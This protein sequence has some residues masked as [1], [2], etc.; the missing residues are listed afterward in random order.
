MYEVKIESDLNKIKICICL[1][2]IIQIINI[3]CLKKSFEKHPT[4]SQ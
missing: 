1:L 3:S 2:Y 4:I